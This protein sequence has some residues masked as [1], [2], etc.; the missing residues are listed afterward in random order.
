MRNFFSLLNPFRVISNIKD[1]S[2]FDGMIK[3]FAEYLAFKKKGEYWNKENKLALKYRLVFFFSLLLI[4]NSVYLI[5]NKKTFT[6]EVQENYQKAILGTRELSKDFPLR[7]FSYINFWYRAKDDLSLFEL[8]DA[9][10]NPL[11][12]S[13]VSGLIEKDL[14]NGSAELGGI[15]FLKNKKLNFIVLESAFLSVAKDIEKSL[16]NEKDFLKKFELYKPEIEK[17]F[18]DDLAILA[19]NRWLKRD[20]GNK[21]AKKRYLRHSIM[22]SN[23]SYFLDI[24]AVMEQFYAFDIGDY[25]GNFHIHRY[26]DP[27]SQ[28]DL[29]GSIIEDKYVIISQSNKKFKIAWLKNGKINYISKQFSY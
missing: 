19:L 11:F 22:L 12:I 7:I 17:R 14:R 10:E 3:P 13:D 9:F 26:G 15:I 4:V 2:F 18:G 28:V 21:D 27:V 20:P 16:S 24:D 8:K 5:S 6:E 25:L 1:I 29:E 23:Y